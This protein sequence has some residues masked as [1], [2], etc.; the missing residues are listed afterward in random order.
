[1][2]EF[3]FTWKDYQKW[4]ADSVQHMYG[5]LDFTDVTLV[6]DDLKQIRAHKFVLS[7]SS[8]FFEKV[9]QVTPN[10]SAIL[11]IKSVQHQELSLLIQFIYKGEVKVPRERLEEFMEAAQD[12][13]IKGLLES[14]IDTESALEEYSVDDFTNTESEKFPDTENKAD[15][16]QYE[17]SLV[18]KCNKC[19]AE[20]E[21]NRKHTKRSFLLHMNKVHGKFIKE[22]KCSHPCNFSSFRKENHDKHKLS[23]Q[24]KM[25]SKYMACPNCERRFKT[26]KKY[27]GH[28][29]S[30]RCEK[31]FIC[32]MCT[33]SFKTETKLSEH[34]SQNTC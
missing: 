13:Q 3:T 12:L 29:K 23:Q 2:E 22:W 14:D 1:M 20:F 32:D 19:N 24:C 10:N 30:R 28:L 18:L 6:S 9:L 4:T 17:I 31:Q 16:N 34:I 27:K 25:N 21:R 8:Q 26:E 33:A 15:L 7:A 11:F 5:K